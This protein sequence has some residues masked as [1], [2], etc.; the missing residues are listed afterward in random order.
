MLALCGMLFVFLVLSCLLSY[1]IGWEM[2]SKETR[3]AFGTQVG[4]DFLTLLGK[5]RGSI[6]N[7]G[8]R[9]I[10]TKPV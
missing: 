4:N 2:Q 8:F 1:W 7:H 5:L 6:R 9:S 10:A 3:P